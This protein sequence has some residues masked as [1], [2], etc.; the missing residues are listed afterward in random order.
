MKG[1][2]VL[3]AGAANVSWSTQGASLI[4]SLV[5]ALDVCVNLVCICLRSPNAGLCLFSGTRRFLW[6][7]WGTRWTSKARGR[8]RPAKARPWPRSGAARSW[9]RRPRAKP[10]LTN[11]LPRLFG[12][13]TTPPSRTRMIP[14][15]PL[16]IYN[17]PWAAKKQTNRPGKKSTQRKLFRLAAEKHT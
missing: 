2:K 11:C 13:W 4:S 9:R 15:A 1:H 12:R 14:A 3:F 5:L 6:F 8:C 16:A 7:W 10:W 17:S